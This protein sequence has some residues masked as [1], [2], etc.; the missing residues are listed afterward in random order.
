MFEG[1]QLW[2]N[3]WQR[4]T[5]AA[6]WQA[7]ATAASFIEANAFAVTLAATPS[8]ELGFGCGVICGCLWHLRLWLRLRPAAGGPAVQRMLPSHASIPRVFL[9]FQPFHHLME[10]L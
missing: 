8:S 6:P 3:L 2:E 10:S 5:E 7:A 1:I 9:G 4:L